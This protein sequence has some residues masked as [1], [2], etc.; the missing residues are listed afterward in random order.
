MQSQ[1][2]PLVSVVIPAFNAA[3]TIHECLASVLGQSEGDLE[4]IVCDDASTDGTL[5]II[6]GLSDSRVHVIRNAVN[7]G[8]GATRDNA[9]AAAKGKWI[10]VIDADDAW[11]PSRLEA[12]IAGAKMDANAMMFDDILICHHVGNRLRPWQPLRGTRAFGSDGENAVEVP[13]AS[14]VSARHFLIKPLIPS[15]ALKARGIR[16]SDL[17]FSADTEFF[18]RLIAA[19]MRMHYIPLPYYFYRITP[20]SMSATTERARLMRDMLI[21]VLPLFERDAEILRALRR[22]ISYREFT[23]A[24]KSGDISNA[25]RLAWKNPTLVTELVAR[26]V[27]ELQYNFDRS[28]HGGSG[29]GTRVNQPR[30]SM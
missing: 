19:G 3:K 27:G 10:A 4:V 14:W 9:I 8:E 29:R 25:F 23:M 16:H 18:L 20:G 15:A 28:L 24:I 21:S 5:D 12:L 2:R 1:V 30:K 13:P 26:S 6:E 17:R 7:L 11:H 22:K